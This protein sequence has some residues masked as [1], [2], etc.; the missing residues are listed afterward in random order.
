[1]G[2]QFL[3]NPAHVEINGIKVSL[4]SADALSPLLRNFVLR[5]EGRKM[6]EALRLLL[7]Q[8]GLFPVVPRDPAQVCEARA[9]ALDFPGGVLPDVCIFPSITGTVKGTLV[10]DTIFVNPRS[11]CRPAALGTFAELW[12]TP[13]TGGKSTPL[14]E[15]FRVDSHRIGSRSL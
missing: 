4:T 3:P 5:P 13:T 12:L 10:D 9:A 11:L 6:D 1:M 8:Q 14:G 15:R 2:I 7:L